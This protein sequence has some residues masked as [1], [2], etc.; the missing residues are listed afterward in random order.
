MQMIDLSNAGSLTTEDYTAIWQAILGENATQKEI[1][2]L[3]DFSLQTA[4]TYQRG[5]NISRRNG[6]KILNAWNSFVENGSAPAQDGLVDEDDGTR[7]FVSVPM[8]RCRESGRIYTM[9]KV[10]GGLVGNVTGPVLSD[11]EVVARIDGRF[12][13]MTQITRRMLR[14]KVRS[15]IVQAAAGVGKTFTIEQE[16]KRHTANEKAAGRDF[17]S[18]VLSGG[19]V[20]AFALYKALYRARKG[21][22][23]VLDD[24]DSFLDADE[25]LNMIK[26]ALDTSAERVLTWSKKNGEVFC[27]I[28]MRAKAEREAIKEAAKDPDNARSE[29]TIYE[30]LTFGLIPDTFEF[31]GAMIFITNLDFKGIAT[32]GG[33]RAPH[34][35]AMIDRSLFVDLTIQNLRDKTLWCTHVFRKHMTAGMSDA[36]VDEIVKFVESNSTKF[37]S[38]SL[39]LFLA[40]GEL[41][42]DP[43]DGGNWKDIIEATKFK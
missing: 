14:N 29:D 41:A 9:D 35:T 15:M 43:E 20:S 25:T 8:A 28:A 2:A 11:D 19:G 4:G 40:I 16:L 31:E 23:V 26:N 38:M 5:G 39:R 13:I 6:T 36:L 22:V 21:G 37:F 27:P 42:G 10:T 30:D 12:N 34:I 17:Y 7:P 1:G 33:T 32:S 24:N 18:K 3:F